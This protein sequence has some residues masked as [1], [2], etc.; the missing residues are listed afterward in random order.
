MESSYLP[1][2]GVPLRSEDLL[3]NPYSKVKDTNLVDLSQPSADRQ[4][5]VTL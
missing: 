4:T 3:K 5:N 1:N 2:S